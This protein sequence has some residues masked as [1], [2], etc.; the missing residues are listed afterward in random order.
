MRQ[1]AYW[2][3]TNGEIIPVATIHITEVIKDPG[4]FGSTSEQIVAQYAECRE[5][6]GHEGRARQSIM[7]DL[8]HNNGWIRVRYT[9]RSDLW[10]VELAALNDDIRRVLAAFFKQ[11]DVVGEYKYA[12]VK[13][14]ELFSV[15]GIST[16]HLSLNTLEPIG[17]P[18]R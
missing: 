6:I 18:T 10:I 2:V 15:G 1:K 17:A 3:H 5:P 11:P 12:T 13:I 16:H 8:I 9:P 7:S 4:R 14:V